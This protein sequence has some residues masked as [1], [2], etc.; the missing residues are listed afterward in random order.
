[1]RCETCNT[2]LPDSG[3]KLWMSGKQVCPFCFRTLISS[4]RAETTAAESGAVTGVTSAIIHA[5]AAVVSEAGAI[6]P[7]AKELDADWIGPNTTVPTAPTV[8]LVPSG[9]EFALAT[10]I[11]PA[12]TMVPPV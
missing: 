8:R 12:L 5:N 4:K 3:V 10:I 1:M 11:V 6:R 9:R 7:S 2:E